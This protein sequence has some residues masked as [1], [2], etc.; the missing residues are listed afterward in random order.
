MATL[1]EQL[2]S[3]TDGSSLSADIGGQ[4][5]NFLQIVQLVKQLIDAPPGD[6]SGYLSHLQSLP[7]PEVSIGGDLGAAFS[8]ILPALQG[9]TSGLLEPLLGAVGSIGESVGGMGATFSRLLGVIQDLQ[10][11]FATDLSCGLVAALA[12]LPATETPA[13][14]GGGEPPPEPAPPATPPAVLSPER[15]NFV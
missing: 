2:Q 1:L 6:F 15:N 12:P 10:K 13:E 4:A 9:D 8:G 7:L 11:L 14:E 3:A 5:G